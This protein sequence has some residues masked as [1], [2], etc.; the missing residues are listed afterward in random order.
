MR[1]TYWKVVWHDRDG[2]LRIDY[3]TYSADASKAWH[4]YVA[5]VGG[6]MQGMQVT[7]QLPPKEGPRHVVQER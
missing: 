1:K 6:T 3:A 7:S 5:S 4:D 2:N